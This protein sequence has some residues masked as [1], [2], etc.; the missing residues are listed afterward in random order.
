[1]RE[2]HRSAALA[3]PAAMRRRRAG[4]V[5]QMPGRGS[6]VC[7]LPSGQATGVAGATHGARAAGSLQWQRLPVLAR[8]FFGDQAIEID[9]QAACL[10]R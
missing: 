9:Q 3:L 2:F 10:G 1:M 6:S 5:D 4:R 8:F 7:S